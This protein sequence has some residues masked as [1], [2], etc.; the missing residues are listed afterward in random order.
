MTFIRGS[1]LVTPR[2]PRIY[3]LGVCQV[4]QA[5][6][7]CSFSFS[8]FIICFLFLFFEENIFLVFSFSPTQH[9]V[10]KN[11]LL[12]FCNKKTAT[13][14]DGK[15]FNSIHAP[16]VFSY[17]VSKEIQHRLCIHLEKYTIT[18]NMFVQHPT[19]YLQSFEE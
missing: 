1:N 2:I 14:N 11:F 10:F 3:P 13:Q 5:C 9:L 4:R 12:F 18:C 17:G 7:A 6:F 16:Q 15:L 19:C 8:M